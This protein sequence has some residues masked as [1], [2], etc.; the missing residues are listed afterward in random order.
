MHYVYKLLKNVFFFFKKKTKQEILAS[1]LAQIA[2]T[3]EIIE[4]CVDPYTII[5]K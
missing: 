5:I 4:M 3:C 2:G 1:T